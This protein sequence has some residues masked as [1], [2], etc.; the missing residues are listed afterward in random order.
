MENTF[1]DATMAAAPAST[2]ELLT[3][4]EAAGYLRR[5]TKTLAYWACRRKGY[6][7][8]VRVGRAPMYRKQDLE[9]FLNENTVGTPTENGEA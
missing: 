8:M 6:L 5:K 3:R 2:S 4:E 7:K 9:V 1:G